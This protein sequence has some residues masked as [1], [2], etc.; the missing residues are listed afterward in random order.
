MLRTLA[1]SS[2]QMCCVI[3]R[4]D[5]GAKVLHK[6]GTR[7]YPSWP[8]CPALELLLRGA[9]IIF[10]QANLLNWHFISDCFIFHYLSLPTKAKNDFFWLKRTREGSHFRC[11]V[12]F[13]YEMKLCGRTVTFDVPALIVAQV[14]LSVRRNTDEQ[15]LLLSTHSNHFK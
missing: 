7:F 9:A 3:I 6:W 14:L 12:T 5:T 1:C 13:K 11:P 15:V 10:H 2:T 8:K 4:V